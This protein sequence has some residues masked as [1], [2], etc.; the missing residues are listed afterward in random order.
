MKRGHVT[1]LLCL[2]SSFGLLTT[3]AFAATPVVT[4]TSPANG[5]SKTSPVN[6]VASASSSCSKGIA[7][8]RIYPSPGFNALTVNANKLNANINL[9][10][11][12]YNTVVQAWD[13]CGGVGKTA[14]KITVTGNR[15]PPPKFLFSSNYNANKVNEYLI[16]ETSGA[17]T[18]TSQGSVTVSGGPSRIAAD[19]GGFR[20]YVAENNSKQLAA[21]FINRS[22]GSL[23][24][25]PG[26]PV[27]LGG[28][29]PTSVAVA[30][31]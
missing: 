14:V 8:M 9:P 11:G 15:M 6:Y 20:L 22:N 13:N 1:L 31:S 3:S 10:A 30:P 4:V 5:S 7:A 24:P 2:I 18:P 19:K 23:S 25:V 27:S 21:F 26:S 29:I 16:N 17:I 28:G 12:T